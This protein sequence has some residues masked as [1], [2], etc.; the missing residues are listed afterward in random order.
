M[1]TVMLVLW[2]NIINLFEKYDLKE[3]ECI[4]LL[5][6]QDRSRIHPGCGFF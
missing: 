6:A 4:F 1:W 5:S 2:L 3:D